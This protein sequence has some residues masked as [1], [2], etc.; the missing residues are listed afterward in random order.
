VNALILPLTV[1]AKV[2]MLPKF[3]TQNVWSHLLN[4]NL[5]QKNQVSVFMGVPTMYSYLI[6]EYDKLFRRKPEMTEYILKHC[7][8]NVRLMI[9]GSAPLPVPTF[10]RWKDITGHA[11]LERYG[12]TEVGMALS[13]PLYQDTARKRQTGFI[14]LPLPLVSARIVSYENSKEVLMEMKGEFNKGLWSSTNDVMEVSTKD[15]VGNLQIKGPSVF[16]SYLNKDK[17]THE[18]FTEDGWFVT[19][20][21]V[22]FSSEA[23]SFK[24]LGRESVDIIKSRGYK[25]SALEMETKLREHSEIEDCAVLGVPDDVLGQKIYALIVHRESKQMVSRKIC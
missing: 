2:I 1:G 20:D 16:S 10:R 14:G 3:E 15:A 7:T 19:G 8:T 23:K 24:I 22:L 12:M 25:I 9:S 17:A 6:Q 5:P 11:I 13:N 4:I 21:S 18:S